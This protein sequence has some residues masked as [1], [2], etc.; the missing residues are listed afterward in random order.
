[1]AQVLSTIDE[2]MLELENNEDSRN[3]LQKRNVK[4]FI[5]SYKYNQAFKNQSFFEEA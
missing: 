1:L 5:H 2:E 4:T 3:Q